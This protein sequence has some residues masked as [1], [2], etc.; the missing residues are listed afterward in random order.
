METIRPLDLFHLIRRENGTNII[1][2]RTP[3]EYEE[4]HIEGTELCPFGQHAKISSMENAEQNKAE[5]E[6]PIYIICRTGTRSRQAAISFE[7]KGYSNTVIVEGGLQEWE[8]LKLSVVRGKKTITIDRQV[9]LVVGSMILG[10]VTLGILVH[11]IL[12]GWAAFVGAGLIFAGLSGTC[13]MAMVL[14]R[15]PWN[16]V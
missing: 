13:G 12:F 10:S 9:Q 2:V 5:L 1:D 15:A 6:V 8:V 3:A 11:P 7:N 16:Q 14:A 4:C